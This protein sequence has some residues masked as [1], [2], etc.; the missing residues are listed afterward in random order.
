M[1]SVRSLAPTFLD[2]YS[3][4]EVAADRISDFIGEWH[5]SDDTEERSLAAYLGLTDEEYDVWLMDTDTLPVL[6]SARRTGRHLHD[7]VADYLADLQ[8][9]ARP[10]DRSSIYALGH[11]LRGQAGH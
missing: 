3:R 10:E 1:S 11:W 2:L 4:G 6:L 5:E 8:R 9:K 7:V